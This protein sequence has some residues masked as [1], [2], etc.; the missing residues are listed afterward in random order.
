M[1]SLLSLCV[2][3]AKSRRVEVWPIISYFGINGK[4]GGIHSVMSKLSGIVS[5]HFPP[6]DV[7]VGGDFTTLGGTSVCRL[8]RWNGTTWESV[9]STSGSFDGTVYGIE[10]AKDGTTYIGGYITSPS[11]GLVAYNGVNFTSLGQF[12]PYPVFRVFLSDAGKLVVSG[13]FT[14]IGNT[15][16]SQAAVHKGQRASCGRRSGLRDNCQNVV[17]TE[18]R[19]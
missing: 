18:R 3:G 4:F 1:T 9:A 15:S 14:T 6:S 11:A 12:A 2:I 8:G 16:V 7:W 5:E 13:G 17:C 10:R 19:C